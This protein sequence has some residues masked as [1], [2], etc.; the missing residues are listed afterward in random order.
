[1]LIEKIHN[2]LF[3]F[4]DHDPDEIDGLIHFW[5]AQNSNALSAAL[6]NE[7]GLK[8]MVNVSEFSKFESLSKKLFLIADK[9][10]LRDTRNYSENERLGGFYPIPT[11]EYTPSYIDQIGKQL[12]KLELPPL[13]I[14]DQVSGFWT[15]DNKTL[16]NGYHVAYAFQQ[17]S[18]IPK[19][20]RNWIMGEGRQYMKSGNIIYAPFIPPLE[21][22]IE[23]LNQN[24][25]LPETFDV[26]P[27]FHR[28]YDWFNEPNINTLQSIEFPYLDNIDIETLQKIKNDDHEVFT[29]FSRSLMNSIQKIKADITTEEFI[30]EIKYIQRNDIDDKLDKLKTKINAISQMQSLRK[31]AVAVGALALNGAMFLGASEI[32]LVS[33]ASASI[34]SMIYER[35]KEL[36]DAALL[37]SNSSYFL[38]QIEESS[39]KT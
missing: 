11:A 37:K 31:K 14:A 36:N 39:K 35:V 22:E 10:V 24:I 30:R 34:G 7:Q 3:D 32:G 16:N 8:L 20:F 18:L 13:T 38:Y 2:D 5:Y 23:F 19:E 28:R 1:M 21:W 9:I 33:G 17:P 25:S 26:T 29:N 15:S 12:S 4:I 6:N 27:C